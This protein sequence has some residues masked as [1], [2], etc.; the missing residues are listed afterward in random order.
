MKNGR[1]HLHIRNLVYSAL[2]LALCLVLPFLT[3]QIETI[4]SFLSPMHLPVLLCGIICSWYWGAI[5]GAVAPLLR[6]VMF[7][8]P[9]LVKAVPMSF[10]LA[11]Y[12]AVAGLLMLLLPKKLPYICNIYVSLI[13]AMIAGRVVWGLATL[14]CFFVG[15]T[16]SMLTFKVFLTT[17]F[18][19]T[20][21]GIV[22]QLLI[23][24][25]VVL[26]MRRAHLVSDN[27]TKKQ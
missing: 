14:V 13:G 9:M 19:G 27:K 22:L 3:G 20:W 12:G 25:P 16:K 10:E 21:A 11:A 15:F 4:G 6:C 18:V 26:A 2:C 8:M 1:M 24:P 17:E 23:I 7:G 5:V